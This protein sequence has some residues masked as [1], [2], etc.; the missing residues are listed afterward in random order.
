VP[1]LDEVDGVGIT[2]SMSLYAAGI[3]SMNASV[4]RYSIPP[5]PP[6]AARG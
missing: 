5:S 1:D 2:R 3:S 4:S 6:A